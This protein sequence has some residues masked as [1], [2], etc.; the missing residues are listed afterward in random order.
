[1]KE[2]PLQ[3]LLEMMCQHHILPTACICIC[4]VLAEHSLSCITGLKSCRN[5]GKHFQL[6]QC[7]CPVF[8]LGHQSSLQPLC[9][10]FFFLHEGLIHRSPAALFSPFHEKCVLSVGD[11]IFCSRKAQFSTCSSPHLFSECP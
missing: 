1:M 3:I 9:G 8:E 6:S 2:S 11:V 7:L 5:P 4:F 10:N